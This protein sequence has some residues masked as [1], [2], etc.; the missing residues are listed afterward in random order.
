MF[1]ESSLCGVYPICQAIV[2]TSLWQG[3]L[4]KGEGCY[5][6][7]PFRTEFFEGLSLH[8]VCMWSVFFGSTVVRGFPD[9]G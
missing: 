5:K 4:S 8:M 2:M 9:D 6:D 1:R 3:S 7:I